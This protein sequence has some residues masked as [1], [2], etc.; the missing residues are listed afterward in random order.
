MGDLQRI[1][2]IFAKALEKEG[3]ERETYLDQVCGGDVRLR[4]DLESLLLAHE[5][6]GQ[7]LEPPVLGIGDSLEDTSPT[8]SPGTVIGGTTR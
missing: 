3:P 1:E 2:P 4:Q 7:F 6:S 8:E 5:G